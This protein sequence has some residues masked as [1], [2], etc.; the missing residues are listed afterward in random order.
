M[1]D[2]I[3]NFLSRVAHGQVE[4]SRDKVLGEYLYFKRRAKEL[5]DKHYEKPTVIPSEFKDNF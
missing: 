2:P 5:L 1:N 4:L 3:K